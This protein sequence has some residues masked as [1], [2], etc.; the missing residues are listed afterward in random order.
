M[1]AL[2]E[3]SHNFRGNSALS[4]WY[5]EFVCALFSPPI[6]QLY[7]EPSN[8]IPVLSGQ[9]CQS[10]GFAEPKMDESF[11]DRKPATSNCRAAV[12]L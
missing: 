4:N 1:G 5:S 2:N 10:Q 12:F 3:Q 6:C 9:T 7:V 11:E 8:A